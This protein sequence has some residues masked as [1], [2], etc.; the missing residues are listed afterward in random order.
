MCLQALQYVKLAHPLIV[1]V[2]QKCVFLSFA[3]KDIIFC[4]VLSHIDIK[5]NEKADT[6]AKSALDLPHVKAGILY[7]NFKHCISQYILSTWQDDGGSFYQASPP[8]GDWQSSYRQYRK[9]VIVLSRVCISHIHLRH[10]YILKK[11][12]PPQCILTVRHFLVECN[13]FV[14]ERN[15][16]FGWSDMMESFIFHPTFNKFFLKQ[17]EMF[18]IF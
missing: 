6:A 17:I 7:S 15:D 3:H 5:G 9:N 13:Y 2:I 10:S 12:P 8:T 4:W 14:Q 18:Y 16:I 1:M 11:D